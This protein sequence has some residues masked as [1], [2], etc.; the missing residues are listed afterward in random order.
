MS[1]FLFASG[2]I[3]VVL[4]VLALIGYIMNIASFVHELGGPLTPLFVARVAGLVLFPL[5]AILGYFA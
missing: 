4:W 2:I 3:G 1:K 5:G